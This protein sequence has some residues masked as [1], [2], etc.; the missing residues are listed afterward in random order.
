VVLATVYGDVHDIGKNLVKTILSNK[1]TPSSTLGKQVSCQTILDKAQEVNATAIGL[2]ARCWSRPASRCRSASP[3]C[4]ARA[5]AS[6]ADRRRGDQP[7][8]RRRAA[9]VD[10]EVSTPGVYYCKDAFEGSTRERA[11]EPEQGAGLVERTGARR[12]SSRRASSSRP[13]NRGAAKQRT[14]RSRPRDVPI[15][16]PPFWGARVTPRPEIPC[17]GM[18]AGMDLKTLY[19]LHWG[20]RGSGAEYDS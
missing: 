6:G 9:L 17:D 10:G 7:Q 3:S 20:A 12:S 5:C 15:P 2:S 8:L 13:R 11:G 4:T 1:S 14:S 16:R 19:R 18:F